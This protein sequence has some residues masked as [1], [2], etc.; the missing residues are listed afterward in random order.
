MT[1]RPLTGLSALTGHQVLIE[2]NSQATPEERS[3]GTADPS[4]A[5]YLAEDYIRRGAQLGEP[6]GPYGPDAQMLGDTSDFWESGGEPDQ[7]P[8]HDYTPLNHAGPWPKGIQSGPVGDIG[9]EATALKLRQLVALH[10]MDMNG[11][12]QSNL[13]R[14]E[15]LNDQWETI[16]QLN[17]GNSGLQDLPKQAKS[18]GFGWGTRDRTQSLAAQNS[19][20]F[21][22]TH[23]HRRWASGHIPGN[24]MWMKPG[25]RPMA[26]GMPGP[27]KLPTGINSPFTGQ[28]TGFS[29][30]PDGAVL[31][32]VPSEY[33]PPPQPTLQNAPVATGDDANVEWY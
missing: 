23:Q 12:A 5:K 2:E 32:N 31:Q 14:E 8:Q 19:F 24:F 15:P 22:Q 10:G 7:D 13:T 26:K 9:P 33:M 3:G 16:D 4:H 29:F 21:D 28:D 11:D 17:R 25:G 30:N 6:M 18:S 27:A 1:A 20:G